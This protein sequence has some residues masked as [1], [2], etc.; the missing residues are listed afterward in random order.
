MNCKISNQE[1]EKYLNKFKKRNN[2]LFAN[3]TVL[4]KGIIFNTNSKLPK[5][6]S[7][8]SE[9]FLLKPFPGF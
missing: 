7:Y 8:D 5:S 3:Y 2:F 9:Y 1:F 6:E 4:K